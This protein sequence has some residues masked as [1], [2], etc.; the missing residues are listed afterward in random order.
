[1]NSGLLMTLEWAL[2]YD[3]A[4]SAREIVLVGSC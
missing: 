3:D 1:M 2:V 4:S